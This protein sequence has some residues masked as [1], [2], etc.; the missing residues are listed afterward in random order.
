MESG[1]RARIGTFSPG[2]REFFGE[3]DARDPE[4]MRTHG[5]HWFDKGWLANVGARRVPIRKGALLYNIFNT[6][7]EGFATGVGGADA[8]GRDVRRPPALARA[9]LHPGGRARRPARWATSGCTAASSR[10][11]RPSQFASDQH[12]ARL[13]QPRQAT[14]CA[15]SSILYL[16]QPAYGTSYVIG[17]IETDKLIAERRRQLGDAVHDAAVHGRVQRG[18]AR[19]DLAAAM[20]TDWAAAG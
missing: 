10:S 2:P 12:A 1:L 20:G 9:R 6:R 18:R 19:A 14:S 8:A 7:T 13:A 17:K 5:Y 11:S 3:V 16:Q 15:A 4:V